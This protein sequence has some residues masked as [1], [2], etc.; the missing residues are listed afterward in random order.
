MAEQVSKAMLEQ[1][2]ASVEISTATSNVAKQI[3][4]INRSN[5][6]HASA[7]EQLIGGLTESGGSPHV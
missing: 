6:E 7:L 5:H 3:A 1:K 2:R 4:S